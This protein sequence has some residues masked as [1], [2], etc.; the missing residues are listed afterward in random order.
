MLLCRFYQSQS[1]RAATGSIQHVRT[2]EVCLKG[3]APINKHMAAI[4]LGSAAPPARPPPQAGAG[5]QQSAM[6]SDQESSS[7]ENSSC[8]AGAQAAA[9]QHGPLCPTSLAVL[10]VCFGTET[11]LTEAP[12][13]HQIPLPDSKTQHSP[14]FSNR[15][16]PP[17]PSY[18]E[19][20]PFS[21]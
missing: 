4:P 8:S 18:V 21:G 9:G 14:C 17:A 5:A 13:R 1:P 6:K 19:P 15:D 3:T 11:P 7:S 12:R 20:L 16:H 2:K 10:K